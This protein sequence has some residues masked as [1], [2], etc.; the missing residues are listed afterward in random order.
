[1]G[2]NWDKM[3]S[4]ESVIS[5]IQVEVLKGGDLGQLSVDQRMSWAAERDTRGLNISPTISWASLQ[6]TCR[7]SMAREEELSQDCRRV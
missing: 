7:C 3:E 5:G 6:S 1:M 4:E 2:R